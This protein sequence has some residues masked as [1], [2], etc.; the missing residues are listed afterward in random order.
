MVI[1]A[2]K[3][4]TKNFIMDF[5]RKVEVTFK[6]KEKSIKDIE[7]DLSKIKNIDILGLLIIYKYIDYTSTH[8][9]FYE[10]KLWIDTY[11]NEIWSKY[12]FDQ[13]IQAY[14]TNNETDKAF[15]DLRVTLDDRFIIAPQALLRN[16]DYSNEYLKKEFIPKIEKYYKG[17]SKV[18]DLIFSCFSEILLNFWEH[19]VNDTRSIIIADGNP[20]VIDIACADTGIG[21]I[22]SLRD[23]LKTTKE[24]E[25]LSQAVEKGVTSKPNTNHMGFGLWL[26]NELVKINNGRLHLYSEG[27]YYYNNYGKI[28]YGS[29]PYWPG[30]IIFI[31]LS[32]KNPKTLTD[33]LHLKVDNN[34]QINFT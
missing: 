34:L 6:W 14:L 13:L 25:L 26:V 20:S 24:S 33:L 28:K 18:T 27:Y 32:L 22:S 23:V 8:R 11:I 2:P 3:N 16:S 17:N 15:K 4:F 1:Q 12:E 29:C 31:N 21:I 7:I 30:T 9:C 5:L 19:A 10:P